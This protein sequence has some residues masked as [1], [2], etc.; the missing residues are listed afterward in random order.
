M[1]NYKALNGQVFIRVK[2]RMN[3][4]T[5]SGLYKDITFDVHAKMMIHAEVI[6]VAS[7]GTNEVMLQIDVGV[8]KPREHDGGLTANNYVRN[9]DIK[10][11]IRVGDKVYFHYLTL[12]D[13]HNFVTFDGE[14]QIFKVGVHD[15]FLSVRPDMFGDYVDKGV[16]TKLFL[17]NQYVVGTEYWGEGWEEVEIEDP[18]SKKITKIA[19]KTN[20]FGMVTE[21]KDKPLTDHAIITD[22]GHGIK[23][24]SRVK[25]VKKGDAVVLT[26]NCEFKNEIENQERWVFT[27]QD[28]LAV[29]E[30]GRIRPVADMVL[31][32][33]K[34]REYKGKLKVDVTKL[35]LNAEGKVMS[36]GRDVDGELLRKGVEVKFSSAGSRVIDDKYALVHDCNIL[37]ILNYAI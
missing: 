28:I 7:G 8:P 26:P 12:E 15:V 1:K 6:S 37:G 18:V 14:W 4:R 36:V 29:L 32:K 30:K 27:H 9:S 22:I 13:P 17:H 10:H 20:S 33:L 3:D 34:D 31:I 2:E 24:Y 5:E 19:G 25:E 21:T 16:K 35:P 23:P 11:D